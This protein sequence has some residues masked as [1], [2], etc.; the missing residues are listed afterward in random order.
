MTISV[1]KADGTRQL[2]EREKVVRTSLGISKES[3]ELI[4][5]RGNAFLF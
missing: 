1:I 3:A 2:L 4:I 5:D